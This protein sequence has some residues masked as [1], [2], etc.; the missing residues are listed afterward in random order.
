[1]NQQTLFVKDQCIV[2]QVITVT[3]K[4][5]QTDRQKQTDRETG[6]ITIHWTAVWLVHSGRMK[7]SLGVFV[8]DNRVAPVLTYLQYCT[9]MSQKS[10]VRQEPVSFNIM[11]PA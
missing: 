8:H 9:D 5:R 10:G 4:D 7:T 3:D 1:M 6:V 2:L 11:I